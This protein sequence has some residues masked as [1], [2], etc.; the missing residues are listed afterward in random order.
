[1]PHLQATI[2]ATTTNNAG[3]TVKGQ[4]DTTGLRANV[5]VDGSTK[6]TRIFGNK[7]RDVTNNAATNSYRFTNN[8]NAANEYATVHGRLKPIFAF[9][10]KLNVTKK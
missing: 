4:E 8:L 3:Y 7:Y 2:T 5:S 1:M 6:T 9:N 10:I